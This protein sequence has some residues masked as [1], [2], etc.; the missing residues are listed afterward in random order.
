[1]SK[2]AI[3]REIFASFHTSAQELYVSNGNN[4][5]R[6]EAYSAVK[7]YIS[8]ILLVI[9]LHNKL[10]KDGMLRELVLHLFYSTFSVL[11]V[12]L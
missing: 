7:S 12:L 3:S 1:M 2:G 6:C 9:H 4:E 11:F 5:S 10:L 8:I